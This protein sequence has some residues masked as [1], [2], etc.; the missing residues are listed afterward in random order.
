[1]TATM[2]T[3]PETSSRPSR[4]VSTWAPLGVVAL[5]PLFLLF[6]RTHQV[7][8]P[9]TFWHI[10]AGDFLLQSWRLSGPDPWSPFTTNTWVLHEW[11]PEL[12]LSLANRV[13]GLT[14]VAWAWY[15]GTVLV[16]FTFYAS[17][18]SQG[19]IVLSAIATVLA[20]LGAAA[21]LTPRPQLVSIAL[22]AVV[23]A[24][25]LSSVRDGR[26]R[27][28]LFPLTWVWACSHGMWF[29]SPLVGGVVVVGL[30]LDRARTKPLR[31]LGALAVACA[32]VGAV[33]PAGPNL[34]LAPLSVSGYTRFV[35]EW[36]PPRLSSPPVA[37]TL[38]L[39]A[40]IAAIWVR[41][42]RRPSWGHVLVWVIA[43]GWALAYTR[44]VAIAA[45]MAAPLV[46]AGIS[47]VLPSEPAESRAQAVRRRRVE[48]VTLAGSL[49]VSA[50]LA[51][52]VLPATTAS[53]DR[54]PTG[55]DAALDRLPAG[56]VVMDEYGL[57]GYLRYRH[58]DLVPVIDE[59]TELFAVDHVQAYLDA[60][61][62]KPGWTDFLQ[63][64]GAKAALV[65]TESAIADA[66]P[67]QLDWR[68]LGTSGDY[69]LLVAPGLSS[70]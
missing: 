37:V 36:D 19:R 51:A 7:G 24:A 4:L 47:S 43:L 62:A 28:W 60:R 8:D 59:R 65:P 32:L 40:V 56:T 20:M 1:M 49:V 3:E 25:W 11:L 50:V 66:L 22:S 52:L 33:T 26:A 12:A 31:T 21:S 39:L 30:L 41:T 17:C 6:N 55:L 27:W 46:V 63:K 48:W 64:T 38:M 10:R 57:G 16:A 5:V 61:G 9:D 69:V 44:T 35:S 68:S 2:A 13:D 23:T 14:G 53:P 18:R 58:A 15:V 29:V 54:M 42:G 70:R 34:L 67:R 45:A